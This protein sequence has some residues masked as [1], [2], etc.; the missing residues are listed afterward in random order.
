[1]GAN[2]AAILSELDGLLE[3]L[4]ALKSRARYEDLSDVE[5]ETTTIVHQIRASISRLAPTGSSYAKDA[6]TACSQF[7]LEPC[8]LRPHLEGIARALRSAYA[9]GQLR[10]FEELV[11]ADLF[12]DFLEM[13]EYL[14][15]EGFKD[16]AA[17]LAG[18]V[19]EESLRHLSVANSIDV[20]DAKGKPKK[21]SALNDELARARHY[22]TIEQKQIAAW[23]GVRNSAAH[24]KYFEYDA[25]QVKTMID[26]IR[27]FL[28]RHPS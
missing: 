9:M 28:M 18:G 26:G 4:D 12:G 5:F 1:M 15:D 16:A 20:T 6:E 17:V 25:G 21:A 22:S 14:L 2:V 10:R 8:Q 11:H 27:G 23:L 3:E 7:L 24:G 13:G 19:L